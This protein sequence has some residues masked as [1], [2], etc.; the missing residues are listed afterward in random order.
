MDCDRATRFV[1]WG[2]TSSRKPS[3]STK[4]S[5]RTSEKVLLTFTTSSISAIYRMCSK[6]RQDVAERQGKR[7]REEMKR[8]GECAVSL[9]VVRIL[10]Y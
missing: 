1:K 2:N 5:V 6:V 8:K 7:G 3:S 10:K 9:Y 4:G